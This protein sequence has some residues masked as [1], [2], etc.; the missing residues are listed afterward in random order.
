[1]RFMLFA[2]VVALVVQTGRGLAQEKTDPAKDDKSQA[3]LDEAQRSYEKALADADAA[4]KK[5]HSD[6]DAALKKAIADA[7]AAHEKA[8]TDADDVRKQAVIEADEAFRNVARRAKQEYLGQVRVARKAALHGEDLAEA[9]RLDAILKRLE[10]EVEA[11]E[12]PARLP[13][14]IVAAWTNAGAKVGWVAVG[15]FGNLTFREGVEETKDEVSGFKFFKWTDGV[16]GKLPQPET[17]F[18]LVL[19]STQVTN[20]GLKELAGLKSLQLLDLKGT[21][22]TDAGV[23]ELRKSLPTLRIGW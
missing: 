1:M 22:V 15:Q 19:N 11:L 3:P 6:A 8:V 14:E 16:I 21:K 17:A 9:N 7:D 5:K 4:Q 12:H 13:T 20:A 2:L 23:A 18:G 10:A